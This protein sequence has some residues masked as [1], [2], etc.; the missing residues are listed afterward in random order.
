MAKITKNIQGVPNDQIR[1][2]VAQISE[3]LE[4]K[5]FEEFFK[6]YE[7][8]KISMNGHQIT[9]FTTKLEA[10]SILKNFGLKVNDPIPLNYQVVIENKE[11]PVYYKTE[12][13]DYRPR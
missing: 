10:I 8:Q 13:D 6:D 4:R 7:I 3:H 9:L 1:I 11:C 5:F 2:V 12:E